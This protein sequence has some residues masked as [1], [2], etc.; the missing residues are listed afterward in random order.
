MTPGLPFVPA[1]AVMVNIYLIFKLSILTLVRFIVW[2]TIGT[3]FHP[4]YV[5]LLRVDLGK[6][7]HQLYASAINASIVESKYYQNRPVQWTWKYDLIIYGLAIT[8]SDKISAKTGMLEVFVLCWQVWVSTST[9]ALSTARWRKKRALVT[10]KILS[11]RWQT[12]HP[13]KSIALQVICSFLSRVSPHG[14]TKESKDSWLLDTS[15][16]CQYWKYKFHYRYF[17]QLILI[18]KLNIWKEF[19]M[20]RQQWRFL[21]NWL[22]SIVF[23]FRTK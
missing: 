13:H 19:I 16:Y 5:A 9:T 20:A 7:I 23:H 1:I 17:V 6:R 18:K 11:S 14:M 3:V 8:S 4:Y 22:R 2:M 21:K 10:S 15:T 12:R